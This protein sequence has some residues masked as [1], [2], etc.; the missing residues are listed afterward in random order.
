MKTIIKLAF[1]FAA[2]TATVQA[3]RA[4]IKHYTFVDAVQE[5]MI[6]ASSSTQEEIAVRVLELADEHAIPIDPEALVV[7]RDPFLIHIEAPYTDAVDLLPGVY[8]H[9]WNFDTNVN[10]RLLED[11]RPRTPT[12]RTR[13]R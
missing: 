9:P 3:G 2:L 4:A 7:R 11:R 12:P 5:S 1:A 8:K 13:R 10:V 6:F